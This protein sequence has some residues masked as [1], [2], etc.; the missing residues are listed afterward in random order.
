MSGFRSGLI[1]TKNPQAADR[2]NR[3][4]SEALYARPPVSTAPH[5]VTLPQFPLVTAAPTSSQN[6]LYLKRIDHVRDSVQIMTVDCLM[7]IDE[8]IDTGTVVVLAIYRLDSVTGSGASSGQMV[9]RLS[10]VWSYRMV[11]RAS[12]AITPPSSLSAS[13]L[14]GYSVDSRLPLVLSPSFDYVFAYGYTGAISGNYVGS[15]T[16]VMFGSSGQV[17]LSS[18]W[19]DAPPV[20]NEEDFISPASVPPVLSVLR[21]VSAPLLTIW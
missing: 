21:P 4:A 2:R 8:G 14:S 19:T 3:A 7:G 15:S 18:G 5:I 9:N 11:G 20:I 13:I 10:R 12:A 1:T 17:A 16:S 6:V